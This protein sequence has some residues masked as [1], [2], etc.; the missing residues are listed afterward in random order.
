MY[1]CQD[2]S[3]AM[4]KPMKK[5]DVD[6]NWQFSR[7]LPADFLS[8]RHFKVAVVGSKRAGKTTFISRMFD[9]TGDKGSTEMPARM[10]VNATS[11]KGFSLAPYTPRDLNVA[12][13]VGD[14][15]CWTLSEN[16]WFKNEEKNVKFYSAYSIDVPQGRYPVATD[17]IKEGSEDQS[18]DPM[19]F[20]FIFEVNRSD[21][22][23]FYDIAGEDAEKSGNRLSKMIKEAPSGIFYLVDGN[24]NQ[25]GNESVSARI[26]D[27]LGGSVAEHPIAVILTKFDE[28]EKHFDPNCHCLRADAFEMMSGRYEGSLLEE[29]IEL[30]SEEIRAYLAHRGILPDFGP[31][32]N[33]RYF[34][35]SSFADSRAVCHIEQKEGAGGQAE[36]NYLRYE[37]SAKRME[38]PLI[39]ML[40][41]LGCIV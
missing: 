6:S 27:M 22:I 4:G 13:T 41:Q 39:W 5:S 10:M 21:Y 3:D 17:R 38:L 24:S 23:Y 35:M 15:V 14:Q 32:A 8:H 9:V 7:V 30:A 40:R 34:G 25:S 19:R 36:V 33:V 1:C 16:V 12:E 11:G 2:F 29:N 28:L 20:P 26:R 37:S 18:R 31:H